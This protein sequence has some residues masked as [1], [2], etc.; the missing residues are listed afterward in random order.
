MPP[1]FKEDDHAQEKG[2]FESHVDGPSEDI[3][4]PDDLDKEAEENY[5][6]GIKLYILIVGLGLAVFL[7]GLDMTI[8]TVAIPL[9]TEKFQSTADIGWYVSAYLLT[10]CSFQPLSGKLY[11]N[12]SLKVGQF[13]I[14]R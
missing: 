6:S 10:L 12:F 5:M 3:S 9:I 11:T 2:A 13:A 14:L 7:M 8:L 1:S 4:N